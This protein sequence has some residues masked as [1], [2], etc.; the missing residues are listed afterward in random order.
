MAGRILDWHKIDKKFDA[1][2]PHEDPGVIA[3]AEMYA[4]FKKYGL[5]QHLNLKAY[6]RTAS[7]TRPPEL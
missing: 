1:C 7:Q 4:Y 3:C 5:L 2:P 6:E